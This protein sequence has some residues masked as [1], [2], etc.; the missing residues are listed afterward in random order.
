M[1]TTGLDDHPD[2][3]FE[4][5]PGTIAVKSINLDTVGDFYG[6]EA[7]AVLRAGHSID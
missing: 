4:L 3:D 1:L 2:T 7:G 6:T 5:H